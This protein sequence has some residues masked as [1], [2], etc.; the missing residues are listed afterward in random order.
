MLVQQGVHWG[1]HEQT[2]AAARVGAT[3]GDMWWYVSSC[4]ADTA[5]H[6]RA[7]C[8]LSAAS[9]ITSRAHCPAAPLPH[10]RCGCLACPGRCGIS[11]QPRAPCAVTARLHHAGH[12]GGLR[13]WPHQHSSCQQCSGWRRPQSLVLAAAADR[14]GPAAAVASAAQV[15]GRAVCPHR[16]QR[17][18]QQQQQACGGHRRVC[19]LPC[20][21]Q[22]QLR[23][24]CW[25]GHRDV[26]GE[27]GKQ[28]WKT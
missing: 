21:G 12:A 18:Q 9:P 10:T 14:H 24:R 3:H 1:Q 4:I 11:L 25:A 16:Q 17:Q 20:K 26:A 8:V 15:A 28:H 19:W 22:Q 6:P 7:L 2:H 5:Q 27:L 23:R 13:R